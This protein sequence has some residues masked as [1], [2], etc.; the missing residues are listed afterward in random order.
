MVSCLRSA[1]K[2]TRISIR[3]SKC[4]KASKPSDLFGKFRTPGNEFGCLAIK[5]A[6]AK[7]KAPAKKKK[8]AAK[9]KAAICRGEAWSFSII[10]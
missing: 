5:K 4:A 9:K 7:K 6:A 8:A 1:K 3:K 2:P 10:N